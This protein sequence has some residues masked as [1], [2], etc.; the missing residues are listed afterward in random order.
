ML[1]HFLRKYNQKLYNGLLGLS[2][3]GVSIYRFMLK[4]KLLEFAARL[5]FLFLEVG[6]LM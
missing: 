4:S 3:V 5:F 6:G 2:V 1:F